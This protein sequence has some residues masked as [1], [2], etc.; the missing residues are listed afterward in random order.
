MKEFTYPN[1]DYTIL[2]DYKDYH[3]E[4]TIVAIQGYD[5]DGDKPWYGEHCDIKDPNLA[6]KFLHGHIK[7]DGCSNWYFDEQEEGMLHFCGRKYATDIGVLMGKMYDIAKE[8]FKDK[9]SYQWD[10][11]DD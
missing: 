6:P 7:W 2:V 10:S 8:H 5:L 4:F 1:L 11:P 9:F 3:I